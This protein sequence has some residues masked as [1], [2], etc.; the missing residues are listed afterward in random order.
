MD[1]GSSNGIR[2]KGQRVTK[3]SLLPGVIFQIG[4][5]HVQVIDVAAETS[6]VEK[7]V[8]EGDW[9][10]Q[11]IHLIPKVHGENRMS[12]EVRPLSPAIEL[13]FITG[14]QC[15]SVC[16]LGYGPRKFGSSSLDFEL[17][18]DFSPGHAFDIYQGT[19]GPE[20]RTAHPQ[21][22]SVNG[23]HVEIVPLKSGDLITFGKTSIRVDFVT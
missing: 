23:E 2:L 15:E 20:L 11:L 17:Q 16:T 4:K 18:D 13:F 9:R 1:R 10:S 6:Y 7:P 5:T 3:V 12:T 21:I 22:V 14:P 8:E 19:Q